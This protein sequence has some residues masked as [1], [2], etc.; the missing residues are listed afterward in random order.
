MDPLIVV[1]LVFAVLTLCGIVGASFLWVPWILNFLANNKILITNPAEGTAEAIMHYSELD[2]F[3]MSWKG[4][5]LD[6]DWNVVVGEDAVPKEHFMDNV[7][8]GGLKWI[9]LPGA[10]SVRFYDLQWSS[11]RQS[12]VAQDSQPRD[13][14]HIVVPRRRAPSC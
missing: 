5:T 1:F 3:V 2:R 14:Y 9:G 7:L 11:Y 13:L 12:A 8:P 6:A 4:H 10:K